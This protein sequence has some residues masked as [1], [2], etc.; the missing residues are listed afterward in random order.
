MLPRQGTG[1]I[2]F[3]APVAFGFAAGFSG[4]DASSAP[5]FPDWYRGYFSGQLSSLCYLDAY[6]LDI[7]MFNTFSCGPCL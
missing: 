1:R 2:E 4:V 7:K 3:V 5:L 6:F